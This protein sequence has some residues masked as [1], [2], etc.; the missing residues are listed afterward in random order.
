MEL[1]ANPVGAAMRLREITVL[2]GGWSA[3]SYDLNTLPGFVIA[4]NDSAY[5]APRWH[6]AISMDRLW[7]E[8][9][10]EFLKRQGKPVWLRRS[11]IKNFT[12]RDLPQFH[13]F[14]CDHEAV[15]FSEDPGA[16]N[17]KHSGAVA[18]NLAYQ[19]R[20]EKLWLIGF[21]MKLG[22][23]GER[24]W[25][26]DYPWKSGGGSKPGT[27]GGWSRDMARQLA[28]LRAAGID[29]TLCEEIRKG[30]GAVYGAP[31]ASHAPS[32]A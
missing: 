27:L 32:H 18:L 31:I 21:D 14:D 13:A 23:R 30:R 25:H 11:T 15:D 2:A 10:F 22:P 9:R 29:V 5:Y 20:P 3:S 26:P 12:I 28:Q 17:G 16:L 1:L 4:V 6:A 24:H 19:L 8:A 7:S